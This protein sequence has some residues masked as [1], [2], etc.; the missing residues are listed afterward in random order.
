MIIITFHKFQL[1]N[2]Y[3]IKDIQIELIFYTISLLSDFNL[4]FVGCN[5]DNLFK[6][7]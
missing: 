7:L 3:G 5:N 1:I 4:A 6:L 2:R